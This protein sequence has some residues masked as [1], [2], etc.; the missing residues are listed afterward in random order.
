MPCIVHHTCTV[1]HIAL[2]SALLATMSQMHLSDLSK[3]PIIATPFKAPCPQ[4]GGTELA[5]DEGVPKWHQ[6]EKIPPSE[7]TPQ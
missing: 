7:P 6:L 2:H 1:Q 5:I 3:G 4:G